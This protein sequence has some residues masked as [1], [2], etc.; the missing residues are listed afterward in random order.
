MVVN[1]CLDLP[2]RDKGVLLLLHFKFFDHRFRVGRAVTE[3]NNVVRHSRNVWLFEPA[4][5]RKSCYDRRSSIS[6]SFQLVCSTH[7]EEKVWFK[8]LL[9]IKRVILRIED[10]AE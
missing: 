1:Q 3:L 7:Y 6:N 2:T 5:D 8:V 9:R 4:L 10:T